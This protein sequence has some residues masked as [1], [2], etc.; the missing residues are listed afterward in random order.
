MI[1]LIVTTASMTAPFQA[2]RPT[3]IPV[4][5]Q[6]PLASRLV[7]SAGS[8]ILG[9]GRVRS[10]RKDRPATKHKTAPIRCHHQVGSGQN[11]ASQRKLMISQARTA[12]VRPESRLVSALLQLTVN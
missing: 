7:A 9:T 5:L 12:E 8:P 2:R 1:T 6:P 11:E 3:S 10:I 4:G